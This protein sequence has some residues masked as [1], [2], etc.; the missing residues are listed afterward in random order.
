MTQALGLPRILDATRIL[1][2]MAYIYIIR[3]DWCVCGTLDMPRSWRR[4]TSSRA[5]SHHKKRF[6][7]RLPLIFG[8]ACHCMAELT[9]CGS[10]V[11][12]VLIK[13]KLITTSSS[14]SWAETEAEPSIPRQSGTESK[15]AY[16]ITHTPRYTI[17]LQRQRAERWQRTRI[18]DKKRKGRRRG[19][20]EME[21]GSCGPDEDK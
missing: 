1:C 12:V 19:R 13:S 20:D 16:H 4:C 21:Y 14:T 15:H 3:L 17:Y 10:Y 9:V 5:G 6:N 8:V 2:G 7:A 11:A 18:W